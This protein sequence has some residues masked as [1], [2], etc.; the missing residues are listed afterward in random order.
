M[1]SEAFTAAITKAGSMSQLWGA[2]L[3]KTGD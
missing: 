1:L 2:N 3:S